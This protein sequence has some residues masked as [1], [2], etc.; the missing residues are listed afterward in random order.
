VLTDSTTTVDLQLRM[1]GHWWLSITKNRSFSFRRLN[2]TFFHRFSAPNY[3]SV[4]S[5][6][7][8]KSGFWDN[9]Q[10]IIQKHWKCPN[11]VTPKRNNKTFPKIQSIRGFFDNKC[12]FQNRFWNFS[13][14]SDS[15]QIWKIRNAWK[16]SNACLKDNSDS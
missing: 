4:I 9:P 13:S 11:W 6:F 3:D 2:S 16:L 14:T 15:S 8:S 1:F 10:W 12:S 5:F 7:P